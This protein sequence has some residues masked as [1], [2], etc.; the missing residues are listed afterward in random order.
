MRSIRKVI[1]SNEDKATECLKDIKRLESEL[2]SS[3]NKMWGCLFKSRRRKSRFGDQVEDFACLYTARITNFSNY[4]TT[5]YFRISHDSM[6]HE[7]HAD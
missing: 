6:A 7:R 1:A 3:Y 4:P 2:D 5:K